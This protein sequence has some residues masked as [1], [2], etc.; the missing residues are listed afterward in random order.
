MLRLPLESVYVSEKYLRSFR[1]IDMGWGFRKSIKIAPGIRVNLSK[2]GV[3][4]S[5]GGKGFTYN[6][7]GRVTASIPGTGIRF[8]QNLNRRSDGRQDVRLKGTTHLGNEGEERLSKREQATR[9]FVHLLQ[10][11]LAEALRQYFLSHGV[12]VESDDLAEAATLDEHQQFFNDIGPKLETTTR[13]IRLV[14]DIGTISLAEKEKAMGALYEIEAQCKA[15]AGEHHGLDEAADSLHSAILK[16]P[17]SPTYFWSFLFCLTGAIVI[18]S[19]TAVAFAIL[20]VVALYAGLRQR[21]FEKNRMSAQQALESAEQQFSALVV[22]VV[23]PKPE[24]AVPPDRTRPRLMIL[25]A[26]VVLIAGYQLSTQ[27]VGDNGVASTGSTAVDPVSTSA[28]SKKAEKSP[29]ATKSTPGDRAVEQK[30]GFSWIQGMSPSEAVKDPRFKSAFNAVSASDW[31]KI[32]ERLDVSD[33]A[34]IQFKN[35]FYLAQGCKEHACDSDS[36]AFAIKRD[37]G[38]GVIAYRDSGDSGAVKASIRSFAWPDLILAA[39][40]LKPWWNAQMAATKNAYVPAPESTTSQKTSFDC[41]KARSTAE[42][43]ICQDP[44]LAQHDRELAEIFGKAKQMT[45]DPNALREHARQA[46]NYR[47]TTCKDRE[48]LM[49]WYVD[50]KIALREFQ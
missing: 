28:S 32:V 35:G 25:G 20:M 31:K 21:S 1:G 17:E 41:S 44:E 37:T 42:K 8:S 30:T 40:P 10:D 23:S 38:K 2:K 27:S 11:R 49:R 26:I 33:V 50:E 45:S 48:C 6:T 12:Y 39:T 16:W 14:V 24:F 4:T 3:S 19:S 18:G 5:F 29:V 22:A 34:G 9:D 46:W 7:R 36:A 43:L 15:R 47:E 13:A